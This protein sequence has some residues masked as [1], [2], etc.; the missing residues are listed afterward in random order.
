MTKRE[1]MRHVKR[2]IVGYEM[3]E[4]NDMLAWILQSDA[5]GTPR[6]NPHDHDLNGPERA[7]DAHR[8]RA[9]GR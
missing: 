5:N 7:L 8:K 4:S 1:A 6:F 2:I 3:G 9:G